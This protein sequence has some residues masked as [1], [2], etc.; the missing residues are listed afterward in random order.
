MKRVIIKSLKWFGIVVG[1]VILLGMLVAI[2]NHFYYGNGKELKALVENGDKSEYT[3]VTING[4]DESIYVSYKS[5]YPYH[6]VYCLNGGSRSRVIIAKDMSWSSKK[7]MRDLMINSVFDA[8]ETKVLDRYSLSVKTS[9]IFATALQ[10]PF[11]FLSSASDVFFS[12]LK[13]SMTDE[14]EKMSPSVIDICNP[15]W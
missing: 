6:G 7:F 4:K 2:F 10:N 9:V 11:G 3:D 12:K 5:I 15:G 8:K 13:Q 14:V 1:G